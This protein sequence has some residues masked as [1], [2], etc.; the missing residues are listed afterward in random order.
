MYK[1]SMEVVVGLLLFVLG[2]S[3]GKETIKPIAQIMWED[4]CMSGVANSY[5]HGSDDFNADSVVQ[6]Y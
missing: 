4:G 1:I 6:N 2:V 5:I 3:V